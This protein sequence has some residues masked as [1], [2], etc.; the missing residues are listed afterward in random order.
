MKVTLISD[1]PE[2]YNLL[3]PIL[4]GLSTISTMAAVT[5]SEPVPEADLYL[6]DFEPGM[7][8]RW[9]FH[10][11]AQQGHLFLVHRENLDLL[12]VHCPAA[13]GRILLKPVVRA[14]VEAFLEQAL[15]RYQRRSSETDAAPSDCDEMLQSLIQANLRLQE[16]DQDRTNFLARAL[17]DFAAPLTTLNGYCGLL[18][19]EQLGELSGEQKEV[20][21]RMQSGA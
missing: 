5:S 6:W 19:E 1:D 8:I 21:G 13:E 17:H 12:R 14:T 15:K 11:A 4:A 20:V 3:R 7:I 18:A 9:D 10:G 2:L 16:Y